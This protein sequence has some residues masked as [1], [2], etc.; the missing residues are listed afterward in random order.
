M[1]AGDVQAKSLELFGEVAF[2]LPECGWRGSRMTF[3]DQR[4]EM[5]VIHGAAPKDLLPGFVERYIHLGHR[6]I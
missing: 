6:P 4:T 1:T 3:S 5:R 2:G